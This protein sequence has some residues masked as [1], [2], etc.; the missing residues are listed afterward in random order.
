MEESLVERL[1]AAGTEC[2]FDAGHV[3][4]EP[5]Q[6]G[7]GLYLIRHGTVRVEALRDDDP[8]FAA[9]LPLD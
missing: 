5:R 2:E 9:A 6:P 3:M 4:I 1:V 7:S 8:Q